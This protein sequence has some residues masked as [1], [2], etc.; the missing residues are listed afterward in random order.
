M[1]SGSFATLIL[2]DTGGGEG[3]PRSFDG[4]TGRVTQLAWSDDG[5]RALSGSEDRTL[6]LWEVADGRPLLTLE[7]HEAVITAL[8][9][10]WRHDRVLSGAKDG[11]VWL[12]SLEK[13]G[14]LRRFQGH[15]KAITALSLDRA[16]RLALSASADGTVRLW[17]VASGRCLFTHAIGSGAVTQGALAADGHHVLA[18]DDRWRMKLWS[19]HPEKRE[20]APFMLSRIRDSETVLATQ[21]AYDQEI[22]AARR[23][24]KV[25]DAALALE[26]VRNA[27]AQTGFDRGAEAMAICARLCRLLPRHRL[28][29]AWEYFVVPD[30]HPELNDVLFDEDGRFLFSG[31]GDGRLCRWDLETGRLSRQVSFPGGAVDAIDLSYNG[32]IAAAAL[33]DHTVRLWDPRSDDGAG[34]VLRGHEGPVTA[35]V[36]SVDG[37]HVLSGGADKTVRLWDVASGVVLKTL[38]G[39]WDTV[40][41]VALSFD[42]AYALAGSRDGTLKIW[43]LARTEQSKHNCEGHQGPVTAISLRLDGRMVLTGSEDGTLKLWDVATGF[44]QRTFESDGRVVAS[45][46][47]SQDGRHALSGGKNGTIRI[48]EVETGRCLFTLEGH[49]KGV[50]ALRFNRDTGFFLSGGRDG[51]IKQWV[52]DWSFA[53]GEEPDRGEGEALDGEKKPEETGKVAEESGWLGGVMKTIFKK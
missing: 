26:H 35:V 25:R 19:I 14:R 21:T 13:A 11:S 28:R 16:G 43:N 23:A 24:L 49:D 41:S 18:M 30:R 10:D 20:R 12:W 51:V 38:K 47:L 7:G 3:D 44:C 9:V 37:R 39:P 53:K 2:R 42:G 36:M 48:W 52:L 40:T 32:E 15:L 33:A 17:E 34:T 27:R 1:L 22:E 46:V 45:V 50:C 4:H 5:R 29:G 8:A 31:G 6:R